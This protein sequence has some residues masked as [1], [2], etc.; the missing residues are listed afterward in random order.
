MNTF[1]I[2]WALAGVAA[3][4]VYTFAGRPYAP[5]NLTRLSN[6]PLRERWPAE[7][8]LVAAAAFAGLFEVFVVARALR[9]HWGPR[10]GIR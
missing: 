4:T 10:G 5:L 6:R 9:R 3:Q 2:L 7:I 1:F 8:L